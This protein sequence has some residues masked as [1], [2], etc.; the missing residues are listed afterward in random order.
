MTEIEIQIAMQTAEMVSEVVRLRDEIHDSV[1]VP[2]T[3]EP[4]D[5]EDR[6]YLDQLD[7]VIGDCVAV[8]DRTHR[9]WQRTRCR[10]PTALA[11]QLIFASC[12]HAATQQRK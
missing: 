11:V 10:I 9:L 2:G 5:P 7:E 1:S 8:L 3:G 4:L 6:A 12:R